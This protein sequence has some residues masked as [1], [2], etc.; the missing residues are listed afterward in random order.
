M[1]MATGRKNWRPPDFH[2]IKRGMPADTQREPYLC[3]AIA[4]ACDVLEAFGDNGEPLRLRDVADRTG[5]SVSTAFRIMTTLGKRGLISRT[6]DRLYTLNISRPKRR[7]YKFGYA[8]QSREFAF[9]RAIGDGIAAAAAGA[10]IDLVVVDNQYSAK[11]A[12]RNAER[13]VRERVDL[14]I[15][16]QT[17]EHVAPVISA[18]L[19]AANIPI[20]ALEIPHPGATYY[21][22]NNY[23]AGELGGH[24][25][26][27]WAQQHWKGCVDEVLLLELPIAGS[28]P[29][30]RLTG[31][32]DGIRKTIRSLPDSQ[33][34]WIDG[35]GQFGASL[36]AVRKH[37]RHSRSQRVLISGINDPSVLGA[38][39]AF[40]EAGRAEGCAA[41]GQN[42][43][44]EGRTELRKASTQFVGSIAYFPERYGKGLIPLCIDLLER[45][46]VPPAVFVTHQLV[47]KDSVDRIYPND[48]LIGAGEQDQPWLR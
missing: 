24:F 5:L 39:R 44:M 9:S 37:L 28:L 7:R 47:T 26:G 2:G 27:R 38:L 18:K 22:A 20:V 13:F 42:A 25:L 16:F 4:R 17:D 36:D 1:R 40:E 32:L 6:S 10:N 30:S 45:K 14:V 21:G 8:A 12:L 29:R 11:T 19:I 23:H 48:A 15:E 41:M 35:N 46:P 43:S 33:V 31:T 34:H 3:Q